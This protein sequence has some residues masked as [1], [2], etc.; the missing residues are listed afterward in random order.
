MLNFINVFRV[1]KHICLNVVAHARR[2][3]LLGL[4]ESY[5]VHL[6]PEYVEPKSAGQVCM[7]VA[8]GT[9]SHAGGLKRCGGG[10]GVRGH[11]GNDRYT[12][13]IANRKRSTRWLHSPARTAFSS[14]TAPP[15]ALDLT[16]CALLSGGRTGQMI[17]KREK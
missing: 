14:T 11:D 9:R 3:F 16:F 17:E 8:A 6:I 15:L 7:A 13:T 5:Y 4:V 12:Y 10:G 1:P 2:F